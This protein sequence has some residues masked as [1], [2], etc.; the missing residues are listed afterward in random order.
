VRFTERLV[1]VEDRLRTAQ[2]NLHGIAVA[3]HR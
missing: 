2:G 3:V 1:N